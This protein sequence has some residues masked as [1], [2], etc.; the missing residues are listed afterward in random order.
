MIGRT[1]AL[2]TN[3]AISH[4]KSDGLDLTSLLAAAPKPHD[5]VAVYKN[6]SAKIT[7]WIRL[8]TTS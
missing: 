7:A 1:D 8:L 5:A 2:E 4:W 3:K 6:H